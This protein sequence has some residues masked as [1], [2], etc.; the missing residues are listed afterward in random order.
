MVPKSFLS[1]LLPVHAF[2]LH[3]VFLNFNIVQNISEG[4]LRNR[5]LELIHRVY[6]SI[7]LG[8]DQWIYI[9]NKFLGCWSWYW[10]HWG[11]AS[12]TPLSSESFWCVCVCLTCWVPSS[13]LWTMDSILPV[14][15]VAGFLIQEYWGGFPFPSPRLF[16]YLSGSNKFRPSPRF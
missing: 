4:L 6:N 10:V 7:G 14:S 2:S 9:L 1:H 12:V 16:W 8:W 3:I 15:S 5:L 13:T 11:S